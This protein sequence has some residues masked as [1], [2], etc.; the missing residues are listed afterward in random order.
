M[1]ENKHCL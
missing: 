1:F